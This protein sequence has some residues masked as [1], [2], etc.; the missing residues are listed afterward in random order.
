MLSKTY[1]HCSLAA[2]CFPM[3]ITYFTTGSM[4]QRFGRSIALDYNNCT[5]HKL[6][7]CLISMYWNNA[8]FVWYLCIYPLSTPCTDPRQLSRCIWPGPHFAC[9]PAYYHTYHHT[10]RTPCRHATGAMLCLHVITAC[11][12]SIETL[13]PWLVYGQKFLGSVQ[14]SLCRLTSMTDSK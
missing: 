12:Q 4:Q 13:T 2:N 7:I 14:S 10:Q 1:T 9:L 11:R 6:Y 5:T 3:H 8:S